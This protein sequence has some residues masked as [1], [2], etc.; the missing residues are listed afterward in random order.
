MGP[1]GFRAG[2]SGLGSPPARFI[3]RRGR[4]ARRACEHYGS[5]LQSEQLRCGASPPLGRTSPEGTLCTSHVRS[6]ECTRGC[7]E[8]SSLPR[9]SD[10]D[11]VSPS[12]VLLYYQQARG[13]TFAQ[14]NLKYP[15]G[16]IHAI[17]AWQKAA[18]SVYEVRF[19]SYGT[20]RALD[21][22]HGF[23]L[24]T[25]RRHNL[26]PLCTACHRIAN[27]LVACKRFTHTNNLRDCCS[28]LRVTPPSRR[29][30]QS[31]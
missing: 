20:A 11:V 19:P 17:C 24:I 5:I 12:F 7:G 29:D 6:G 4:R 10:C 2:S 8:G 22:L 21:N 27:C 18:M 28:F 14:Y 31:A 26:T 25:P 1:L 23:C 15:H 30:S 3:W 9:T 16:E 13:L